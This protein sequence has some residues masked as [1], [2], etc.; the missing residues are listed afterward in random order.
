VNAF[1]NILTY[2]AGDF[3]AKTLNFLVYVYLARI[4][5]VAN[6]G[7]LEFATSI[8]AYFLVLA[9]G[10]LEVWATREAAQG[11]DIS[12][13][14]GRIVLLRLIAAVVSFTLLLG[15]SPWLPAYPGL[16]LLLFVFGMTLFV[17]AVNLKW[18]FV[19]QH[20][21][22]PAAAGL[23]LAQVIFAVA[24]VLWIR[25]PSQVIW[26]P[27]F[28][29]LSEVILALYFWVQY[30]RTQGPMRLSLTRQGA[31]D[32]LR[33]ALEIGLSS[34]LGLVSYNLNFILLGF[35]LGPAAV[36]LYAAASKP[37][38]AALGI[39]LSYLLG[40][41][42]VLARTIITNRE[43]FKRTVIRSLRLSAV[44]A[45][46]LG[47]AGSFMAETLV[48]L[49]YGQE[50][51]EAVLAAQLLFW[52]AATVILRGTFYQALN[53]AGYTRVNLASAIV[54]TIV[55]IALDLVLLPRW[56]VSGAALAALIATFVW[57]VPLV[58]FMFRW[59]VQVNVVH[60]IAQP[61]IAATLMAISL[62]VS[63][64][65]DW[66]W[67]LGFGVIVYFLTLL[68]L[69]ETEVR[70]WLQVRKLRVPTASE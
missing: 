13:L 54:A 64:S 10:G 55:N 18:V 41:F 51:G 8:L 50:Y 39:P 30:V 38:T 27:A 17:Q 19:G 25:E 16:Q 45:I 53:A 4:L 11:R 56:G 66:P 60:L 61:V 21:M 23:M 37:S 36:G 52:A 57:L 69:T 1:R 29:L 9:D 15:L 7:A 40:L 46:P 49:V 67:R 32:L 2:S 62:I 68:L 20:R 12:Q 35:M 59:V 24:I 28:R 34:G 26:V 5:G 70:S 3:V 58:V 22:A 42:P 47:I 65:A 63:Q 44:C 31:M 14:A 33:P 6:Y 43:S 48:R